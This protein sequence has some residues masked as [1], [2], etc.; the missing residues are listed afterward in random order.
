MSDPENF[1]FDV[2]VRDRML[3]SGLLVE[4]ELDQ[5][6]QS[7]PDVEDQGEPLGLGQPAIGRGESVAVVRPAPA[8]VAAAPVHNIDE[9]DD[10]ED[11][12]DEQDDDED[13]DEDDGVQAASAA[14]PAPAPVPVAAS[15][16]VAG[17]VSKDGEAEDGDSEGEAIKANVGAG[18]GDATQG[19]G[20]AAGS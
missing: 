18:A 17:S 13:E 19:G 6:L 14:A 16:S 2:R 20:E 12:D 4:A 11:E 3:R 10:E 15:T 1:K 8:F 5:L 9:E 7:L